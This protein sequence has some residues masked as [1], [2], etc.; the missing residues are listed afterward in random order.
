VT[1]RR[2]E[3]GGLLKK[4]EVG[5]GGFDPKAESAGTME[6]VHKGLGCHSEKEKGAHFNE[7]F[8]SG[9]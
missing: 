6:G 1:L 8:R 3:K 7:Q 5:H 2:K 4:A 9:G